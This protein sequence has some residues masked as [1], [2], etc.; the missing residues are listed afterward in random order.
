[1][2]P[3]PDWQREQIRRHTALL[4]F[5]SEELQDVTSHAP[6]SLTGSF[7]G[8]IAVGRI[9]EHDGHDLSRRN[10]E[11]RSADALAGKQQGNLHAI[12]WRPIQVL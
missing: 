1:M 9:R 5:P 8:V 7:E 2:L 11:I 3:T 10:F 12:R 6:G 4:N